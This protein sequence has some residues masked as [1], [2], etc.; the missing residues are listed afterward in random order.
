MVLFHGPLKNITKL[1]DNLKIVLSAI[2]KITFGTT[3]KD[4]KMQQNT[5]LSLI[6]GFSIVKGKKQNRG[7]Y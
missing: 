3:P 5:N 6:L 1:A 2:T 4:T 7:L